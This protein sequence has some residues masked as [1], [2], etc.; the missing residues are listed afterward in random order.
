[1]DTDEQL[2]LHHEA[3]RTLYED[4]NDEMC[5]LQERAFELEGMD[6]YSHSKNGIEAEVIPT[7]QRSLE[8]LTEQSKVLEGTVATA[9]ESLEERKKLHSAN[10][11]LADANNALEGALTQELKKQEDREDQL[12]MLLLKLGHEQEDLKKKREDQRAVVARFEMRLETLKTLVHGTSVEAMQRNIPDQSAIEL[13]T[14]LLLSDARSDAVHAEAWAACLPAAIRENAGLGESFQTLCALHRCFHKAT[15][16]TRSIHERYIE[17][18]T[19]ALLPE[20]ATPMLWLSRIYLAVALCAVVCVGI[21]GRLRRCS[22]QRYMS[23]INLPVMRACA[24]GES[25]L[26]DVLGVLGSEAWTSCNTISSA[27]LPSHLLPSL[28]ALCALFTSLQNSVF[29][30]EPFVSWQSASCV[31]EALRAVCVQ[32]FYASCGA[33]GARKSQWLRL[34]ARAN[35]LATA[36]AKLLQCSDLGGRG[37][38][39]PVGIEPLVD[40]PTGAVSDELSKP[41]ESATLSQTLLDALTVQVLALEHHA[42]HEQNPDEAA[43]GALERALDYSLMHLDTLEK[44]TEGLQELKVVSSEVTQPPWVQ[45]CDEMRAKIETADSSVPVEKKMVESD[46]Q[47]AIVS[48]QSID[49]KLADVRNALVKAEH[50][51]G[52]ARINAERCDIA[53]DS[54]LRLRRQA[55]FHMAKRGSLEDEIGAEHARKE[56]VVEASAKTRN[57][58]RELQQQHL[59]CERLLQKRSNNAV[60]PE[61]ITALHQLCTR[62]RSELIALRRRSGMSMTTLVPRMFAPSSL[63]EYP[64][65][66]VSGFID[67]SDWM[68]ESRLVSPEGLF[69][70]WERLQE[71]RTNHLFE[72]SSATVVNLDELYSCSGENQTTKLDNVADE[73]REVKEKVFELLQEVTGVRKQQSVGI[74]IGAPAFA[75]IPLTRYLKTTAGAAFRESVAKVSIPFSAADKSSFS[76]PVLA[77]PEQLLAV[78]NVFL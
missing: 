58:F 31:V 65:S 67:R 12:H 36:F 72:Q 66:H 27:D 20:T 53:L 18:A 45:A 71:V 47:S 69:S 77:D 70:C 19:L 37:L 16:I 62:Q 26:D 74:G 11:E 15:A 50:E 35:K 57:R 55:Q 4:H 25:T 1:V 63:A 42:T 76:F 28:N 22:V 17:D 7:L 30:D 75:S 60:S 44:M 40:T 8:Q 73:S 24:S 34:Y 33:G 13:S 48:R 38:L 64:S 9:R 54:V 41:T 10:D 78:H 14:L 56:I 23:L 5:F 29:K 49:A 43:V 59:E 52:V 32:A 61:E 2:K 51:F 39:D 68:K 21:L 46:M 6:G 3:L